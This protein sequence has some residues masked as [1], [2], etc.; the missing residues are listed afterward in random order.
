ML[1]IGVVILVIGHQLWLQTRGWQFN[2]LS[3]YFLCDLMIFALLGLGTLVNPLPHRDLIEELAFCLYVWSGLIAYYFGLHLRAF[4]IS[5][6]LKSAVLQIIPF[7]RY[8]GLTTLFLVGILLLL[9]AITLFQRAQA[10]GMSMM[11]ILTLSAIQVYSSVVE[12]Q[13]GALPVILIYLVSV[14]S[15]IHLYRSLKQHRWLQAFILYLSINV[16]NLL[17]A[18]T[19]MPIIMGL[20]IP[21]AYYHYTKRRISG[22][23]LVG[24][25]LGGP[26]ALTLLHGWRGKDLLAWTVSDRLI[27]E[28]LVMH[29]F[30]RLWEKYYIEENLSLEY[31]LNYFYYS[32]LSAVPRSLWAE[33]PQTSFETRWTINLYGSLLDESKTV[34]IR[35]FTPWGEGLVQ[36]GWIGGVVNLFLYGSILNMAIRFFTRRKHACLV[37]YF[38]SILAATFIRIST[39]GLL[40]TTIIYV[41]GI[42]F[43][44]RYLMPKTT[45]Q[46]G[47]S[48]CV[49]S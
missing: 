40:L 20:S 15:L 9:T 24:I 11:Q 2:A 23:I 19:R 38:H 6:R 26:I 5:L 17:I 8:P 35:T 28:T 10:S 46:E 34:Y 12:K 21:L 22:L 41:F 42:W 37:Y 30:Y 7:K 16:T 4:R 48:P 1:F 44:E 27:D 18:S 43:Y 14:L 47:L 13:L 31:G 45:E 36:F 39:Q 3:P 29:H 25:L 49:S 32:M 33:K